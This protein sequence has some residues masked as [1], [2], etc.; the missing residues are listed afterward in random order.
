MKTNARFLALAASA[1]LLVSSPLVRGDTRAPGAPTPNLPDR[2]LSLA[3]TINFAEAQNGA[4]VKAKKDLEASA[5]VVIQTKAI[6]IPKVQAKGSY[7]DQ[8]RGSVEAIPIP[9]PY[10]ITIPSQNWNASLLLVQSLYEGGRLKSSLRAARLIQDQ[11]VAQFQT[12]LND[13]FLDVR[14]TYYDVLLAEQQITVE[15]ASLALLNSELDDATKRFEAGTVPS[16]NV[17]RAKV[18]AANEKPKL[19]KARNN[20]RVAKNNLANLMGFHLPKDSGED[21]TLRLAGKLEAEP[22]EAGLQ[23]LLSQALRDRPELTTLRKAEKLREEDVITAKAGTRPSLQAFGG[24]AGRNSN[25][26]TDPAKDISGWQAGVQMSWSIFDG[27]LTRGKVMQAR[28][29]KEKADADLDDEIRRI[30]LEVRTAYSDFVE[31]KE[32]LES[33]KK[34]VEEAEESLRLAT[35]RN[36]AGTGTQLDVLDAQ[37]SLTQARTT[38]IQSTHDYEVAVARLQRAVGGGLGLKR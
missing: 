12:V 19:I 6:V 4:I 1:A 37:T 22:F 16:F 3:D 13:T 2:P 29:L 10:T 28:S 20:Y 11:A 17:L 33:Q 15:E 23:A 25:Y 7:Q 5:G 36:Q 18:E 31:A 26:S 14:S 9:P 21:I 24:Y 34:V 32:V 27:N 35:A 8:D 30:E 38:Q